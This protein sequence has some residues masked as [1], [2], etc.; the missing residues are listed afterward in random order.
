MPNSKNVTSKCN[1]DYWRAP[2]GETGEDPAIIVDLKCSIR[3]ESFSIINGFGDFGIKDF[4]LFGSRS[5]E[6]PWKE[7]YNGNLPQG[8]NM[9]EEVR[10]KNYSINGIAQTYF[11]K[12]IECC[13]S[14][15]GGDI[16][17]IT[18]GADLTTTTTAADKTTITLG[19]TTETTSMPERFSISS[20]TETT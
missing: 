17:T 6:G 7:L 15:E 13:E 1:N 9:T 11:V 8:V 18:T 12:D 2:L 19:D 20:S 14:Y 5:M 10:K 4:S 16:T 3:L